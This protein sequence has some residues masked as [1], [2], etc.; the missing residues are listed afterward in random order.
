MVSTGLVRFSSASCGVSVSGGK[1]IESFTPVFFN[2]S[3]RASLKPR[4][5]NFEAL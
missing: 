4:T 2:S 5:A 1:A 3:R